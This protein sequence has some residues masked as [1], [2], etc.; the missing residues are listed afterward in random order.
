MFLILIFANCFAHR[1]LY[2]VTE[3]WELFC[4]F[5]QTTLFR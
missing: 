2:I 5:A 1:I 3:W 4:W